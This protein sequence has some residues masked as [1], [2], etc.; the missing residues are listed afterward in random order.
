MDRFVIEE[1][2][3]KKPC[4]AGIDCLPVV[5]APAKAAVLVAEQPALV[6]EVLVKIQ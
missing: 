3:L 5:V 1:D 2:S 6:L 4:G